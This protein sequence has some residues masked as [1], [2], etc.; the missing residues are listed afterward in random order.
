M[1]TA[2]A[3]W[4]CPVCAWLLPGHLDDCP[5]C[6]TPADWLDLLLALGFALRQLHYWSITGALNRPQFRTVV[7]SVRRR[8]EA[9][10]AA[11]NR[12]EAVPA[13]GGL[14]SRRTCWRCRTTSGPA[15]SVCAACGAPLSTPEVRL[16][17]Y[18]T[19]LCQEV[20]D[21]ARTG[22]LTQAQADHFL[23]ET[24][25]GLADLRTR[26]GTA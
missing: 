1:A 10:T 23:A 16:F 24:T 13:P 22:L 8:Q 9:M 19:F 5:H 3:P 6:R 14:P 20:K 26:L 18:K 21:H 2:P 25:E 7:E 11:A 4:P 12:G 15:A 17:R